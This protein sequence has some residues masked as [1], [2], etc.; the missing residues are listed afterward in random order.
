MVRINNSVKVIFIYLGNDYDKEREAILVRSC[1]TISQHIEL[2]K[3]IE[4]ELCKMKLSVYGQTN[5]DSRFPKRIR[6]NSEL[7]NTEILRPLV[8]ELIHLHQRHKGRL[9]IRRDGA[10]IWEGKTYLVP[11]PEKMS[12]KEYIQLPWE[13]DVTS[14]EKMLLEKVRNLDGN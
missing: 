1:Q 7:S 13:L 11:H 4:I 8:H 6:L 5:L 9:S 12:I 3:E 2:P 10:V 14:K